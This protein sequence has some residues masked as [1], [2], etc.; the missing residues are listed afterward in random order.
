MIDTLLKGFKDQNSLFS[1]SE[2]CLLANVSRSGYYNYD[3]SRKYKE[4]ELSALSGSIVYYCHYLRQKAHLPKA[5]GNQLYQ[6]CKE[7][8]GEKMVIGRDRFFDIL[9]ANNLLLRA[10][11]KRGVP[12]TTFGVVNHGFEDH[13]NRLVK[14]I[15]PTHCRL[16]VSDITYV[17]CSEGFVYLSLTMDAYS[18]IITGYSLQRNLTTKGPHEALKQTVSFYEGHALDVRGLIF[19]SDRGSQYVSKEMTSYEASLG[20]ITSVT[21]TGDPL[22]NSMAERLNSTIK[23]DWLYDFSLLTFEET[24]R[25]L[26]NS[27]LMY[28]TAR[29]HSS[30]SMRTPMQTL[31]ANYPN[32]LISNKKGG[33]SGSSDIHLYDAQ[34]VPTL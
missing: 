31:I 1:I 2:L 20:I 7:Y 11:K 22:H 34:A 28:N 16:C 9:R 27:V 5:G 13:V 8:F 24:E 21:Q 12:R 4:E 33:D 30:V 6:L 14:Y 18:R 17:K 26:D 19:H 15:P 25:A 32:P 29:P 3:H 10:K 23:N